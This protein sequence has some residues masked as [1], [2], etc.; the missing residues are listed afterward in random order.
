MIVMSDFYNHNF[1]EYHKK[2]FSVDMSSVLIPLVRR[3]DSKKACMLDVGC[4]SGRDLL[5]FKQQGFQVTGF[6][7]SPGLAELARKNVGCEVIADDFELYDFTN[8]SVDAILLMGSVVHVPHEKF[9]QIFQNI[10]QAL[11]IKGYVLISLKEGRGKRTDNYGRV[12]YLW[13]DETLRKIFSDNRFS[14]LEYFRQTSKIGTDE[15]WVAY[16]LRKN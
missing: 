1:R 11:K 4:G 2:T 10:M 9:E 5:W 6:E 13:R 7:R 8:L 16:I 15:I 3:L 14:V 12:F